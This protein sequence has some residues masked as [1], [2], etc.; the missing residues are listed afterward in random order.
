MIGACF[1][2]W[3]ATRY[4]LIRD[5]TP[6]CLVRNTFTEACFVGQDPGF[7][8]FPVNVRCSESMQKRPGISCTRSG[9]SSF[10]IGW[11]GPSVY[12]YGAEDRCLKGTCSTDSDCSIF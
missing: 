5:A 2:T 11:Q 7:N 4:Q 3:I 12:C 1:Y 10:C 9:S 8:M 6:W